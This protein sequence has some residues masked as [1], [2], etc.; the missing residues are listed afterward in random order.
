[1]TN[2]LFDIDW[3]KSDHGAQY[4]EG[5]ELVYSN[6]TARSA[7]HFNAPEGYDN[8]VS[9]IGI[10][11]FLRE[12][13]DR[14]DDYFFL[15]DIDDLIADYHH[16]VSASLGREVN[17]DQIRALHSLGYL[18][19]EFRA[20]P[21][22]S[23]CK[24]GVP[25]LVVWNT[26]PEF[27][28]LTNRIE[29]YLS[30]EVWKPIT[31]ATIAFEY[32]RIL[33]RYA[34]LTASDADLGEFTLVDIQAHDFSYRGM[35][36]HR[37]AARSGIGH[38]SCFRGTDSVPAI[39]YI[40]NYYSAHQDAGISVAATE[41]S[42]MCMGSKDGELETIRRLITDVYPD[43]I[44]SIVSDTW[45]F[46][47]VI[48]NTAKELKSEILARD[49]KVVF[50]PDSGDP[51][52]IL[53]GTKDKKGAVELLYDLF[54]GEDTSLLPGE[55]TPLG[56]K[57]LDPHV[58]LIYGDSITL[59]RAQDICQR[60]LEKGFASTNVV[61]GVGSFTYQMIT[62]DT[63]GMAIKATAG[64]V[65]GEAVDVFKDPITDSGTKKSARGFLKVTDSGDLEQ[66][67]HD[68]RDSGQLR[69]VLIDGRHQ[70]ALR[71]WEDIREQ[72]IKL[73]A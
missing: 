15:Q 10:E 39:R 51:A 3:Y 21:E 1:M 37:D 18:P 38:L 49:G 32:R 66:G 31:T 6:M 24:I 73:L 60:L 72:H 56:Y 59:Q 13:V 23:R 69:P 11:S 27:Y 41:H 46:W 67:V 55:D 34:D 33:Q 54:P 68:M 28:W 20:L 43:G 62:R 2:P 64:V 14:W 8:K 22:G 65:N 47:N 4:P 16:Q 40:N 12:L 26:L 58:G 7:H 25:F 17:Y 5:T 52:D 36:G 71:G 9:I 30:A 29:T 19:L 53:C 35:S 57:T 70:G 45:D 42:V 44:V 63:F 50:R 48:T 61:F